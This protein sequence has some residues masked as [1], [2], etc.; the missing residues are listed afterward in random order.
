MLHLVRLQDHDLTCQAPCNCRRPVYHKVGEDPHWNSTWCPQTAAGRQGCAH[1]VHRPPL[2]AP[3]GYWESGLQA[4]CT[5]HQSSTAQRP[6]HIVLLRMHNTCNKNYCGCGIQCWHAFGRNT[7]RVHCSLDRKKPF[8]GSAF[9][10]FPATSNSIFWVFDRSTNMWVG[11]ESSS[12]FESV[13]HLRGLFAP[14]VHRARTVG[15]N[16]LWGKGHSLVP[17]LLH[18]RVLPILEGGADGGRH[19]ITILSDVGDGDARRKP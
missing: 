10:I 9:F 15:Q 17:W 19:P 3:G 18:A 1:S 13:G 7:L 12:I 11:T 8:V 2:W 16:K 14:H 5:P 6:L 4:F